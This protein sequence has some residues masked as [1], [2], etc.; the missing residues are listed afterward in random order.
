MSGKASGAF[1]SFQELKVGQRFHRNCG[2]V[3]VYEKTSFTN[4][5]IVT[6]WSLVDCGPW[7]GAVELLEV[8]K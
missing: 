3:L 6:R 8:V 7:R 2:G 5:A 1:S 4:F